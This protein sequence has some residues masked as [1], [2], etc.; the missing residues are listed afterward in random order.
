M[1]HDKVY[2]ICSNKC[3]VEVPS[4]EEIE[5][6]VKPVFLSTDFIQTDLITEGD[7]IYAD[8]SAVFDLPEGF[9][10]ENCRPVA[11]TMEEHVLGWLQGNRINGPAQMD[12]CTAY[13]HTSLNNVHVSYLQIND[14]SKTTTTLTPRDEIKLGVMLVPIQS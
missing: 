12:R 7:I 9:T 8:A 3:K 11:Y 4:K 5:T 2:G 1:A 13:I 14:N 6:K 10:P